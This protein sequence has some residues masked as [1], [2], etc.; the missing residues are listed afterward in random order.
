MGIGDVS[1]R[2]TQQLLFRSG[3]EIRHIGR[4][5]R[6]QRPSSYSHFEEQAIIDR[7]LRR[8]PGH[9]RFVVD[10][11]AGD[12]VTSSNSLALFEDGWSGLAVEYDPQKFASLAFRYSSFE[13]CRLSRSRVTPANVAALLAAHDTPREFG[14]L[15][16][17]IDSFD[18]DVLDVILRHYRPWL[19]C[20]EV[21]EKIPPP[22]K[23]TVT[24]RDDHCWAGDHFYGQS[25]AMLA[26]LAD[27]HAYALVE[28]EYNNAFLVA[29]EYA[30]S[31]LLTV[32]EIYRR[33]Y[34][35][36]A[37]R[38]ERLPWNRDMESAQGRDSEDTLRFVRSYFSQYEG[39]FVCEL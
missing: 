18:H 3:Y 39:R 15:S 6:S 1:R 24:Y 31:D 17:D 7:H 19:L 10:I 32:D 27:R 9:D 2:A 28:L 37:D 26:D 35:D 22:V 33:G 12:G 16:L 30:P 4:S 38:L 8:L 5:S 14:L 34:L 21:N 20:A 25:I 23:F 13:D 11:A 29:A 36:R